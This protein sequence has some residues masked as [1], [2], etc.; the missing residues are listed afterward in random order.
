MRPPT[1]PADSTAA[2]E[3]RACRSVAAVDTGGGTDGREEHGA[4]RRERSER[5]E[6]RERRGID[7]IKSVN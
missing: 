7:L 3:T 5:S 4:E 6:R 1:L 2:A